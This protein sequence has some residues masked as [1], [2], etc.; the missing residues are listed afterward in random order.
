MVLS[1][2]DGNDAAIPTGGMYRTLGTNSGRNDQTGDVGQ[3]YG[4]VPTVAP[5]NSQNNV[6]GIDRTANNAASSIAQAQ[7]Q[8]LAGL[9]QQMG[10]AQVQYSQG[11]PAGGFQAPM[12]TKDV[13]TVLP[14][15]ADSNENAGAV[16]Q[17][18]RTTTFLLP[19]TGIVRNCF[20][21]LPLADWTDGL[22]AHI[23]TAHQRGVW[24]SFGFTGQIS[25][26][27][28]AVRAY[29][30]G[31]NIEFNPTVMS[32]TQI[33][34]NRVYSSVAISLSDNNKT[35]Q[36]DAVATAGAVM[37]GQSWPKSD[38]S[39]GLVGG[40]QYFFCALSFNDQKP[41][42][43]GAE[44]V[45]RGLHKIGADA[46]SGIAS[47]PPS[48]Q[49]QIVKLQE[50]LPDEKMRIAFSEDG[51]EDARW[52]TVQEFGHVSIAGD[53][54][55]EAKQPV[56]VG[57][58]DGQ[59][60]VA[61]IV[62][63][64]GNWTYDTSV[65][66]TSM[67]LSWDGAEIQNDDYASVGV[68]KDIQRADF[69]YQ[70]MF[71]KES[72]FAVLTQ[73]QKYALYRATGG[74]TYTS[75]SDF[76]AALVR[77]ATDAASIDSQG[78][79]GH[80]LG[81]V[82]VVESP[83]VPME[84][85]YSEMFGYGDGDDSNA[86]SAPRVGSYFVSNGDLRTGSAASK[87]YRIGEKG[88]GGLE[89]VTPAMVNGILFEEAVTIEETG[90]NMTTTE[91]TASGIVT[92]GVHQRVQFID[93]YNDEDTR[94]RVAVSE[95]A[96][97][98]N[99]KAGDGGAQYAFDRLSYGDGKGP[100]G[101]EKK[102]H[103]GRSDNTTHPKGELDM[104]SGQICLNLEQH[105][106]TGEIRVKGSQLSGM[107][108]LDLIQM[109]S[110]LYNYSMR[111]GGNNLTAGPS[112]WYWTGGTQ[113]SAVNDDTATSTSNAVLANAMQADAMAKFAGDDARIPATVDAQ[114]R[115]A[116]LLTSGTYFFQS[117][118]DKLLGKSPD[119]VPGTAANGSRGGAWHENAGMAWNGGSLL[120]PA[121]LVGSGYVGVYDQLVN[122]EAAFSANADAQSH[123]GQVMPTA[124]EVASGE[125]SLR[126]AT[127]TRP[128][129]I[130]SLTTDKPSGKTF[131]LTL[132]D[133]AVQR[134]SGAV[135]TERA[136]GMDDGATNEGIRALVLA[137]SADA[138]AASP[139]SA[140]AISAI[141]G[142]GHKKMPFVFYGAPFKGMQN[143][144]K[145]RKPNS[146]VS[147][148]HWYTGA[149]AQNL[150]YSKMDAAGK[151]AVFDS[152][153]AD[154]TQVRGGVTAEQDPQQASTYA[155]DIG[156]LTPWDTSSCQ[157][158]VVDMVAE[159]K[160]GALD[161]E[162]RIASALTEIGQAAAQS[163]SREVSGRT[164][165]SADYLSGYKPKVI[166]ASTH[167]AR[168]FKTVGGQP[169]KWP[170]ILSGT[171]AS[172]AGPS[173]ESGLKY[174]PNVNSIRNQSQDT[175]SN[176]Q[177]I[178]GGTKQVSWLSSGAA[179][180]CVRGL[181]Q[182]PEE[183]AIGGIVT[184][185][186]DELPISGVPSQ[187]WFGQGAAGG[188]GSASSW[189]LSAAALGENTVSFENADRTVFNS[190][191]LVRQVITPGTNVFATAPVSEAADGQMEF[192]FSSSSTAAKFTTT[193]TRVA[194]GSLLYQCARWP[195]TSPPTSPTRL[196]RPRRPASSRTRAR[197][198]RP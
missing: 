51:A 16:F 143:N 65:M 155:M 75:Q 5:G 6:V 173:D 38:P 68:I 33:E 58:F 132:P 157:W 116:K 171:D 67:G 100:D 93:V 98:E 62:E 130:P 144:Y 193:N 72:P 37:T 82:G 119:Y 131:E 168:L 47:I 149:S 34:S 10:A 180:S 175:V 35:Y 86:T 170:T 11:A 124:S 71:A 94:N 169:S 154:L 77:G 115:D 23:P 44:D 48:V 146:S 14:Q 110:Q 136:A 182:K 139:F 63:H 103:A 159:D 164:L 64:D 74:T 177:L 22:V 108:A 118:K 59:L 163:A 52:H 117:A 187:I 123:S 99:S 88:P 57:G 49:V 24:E 151:K 9:R 84:P 95:A 69:T 150:A 19:H 174:Q 121:K 186:S 179:S 56:L 4:T 183:K 129:Q 158:G 90:A 61:P 148:N 192:P 45:E 141:S 80:L 26:L 36:L 128:Q 105:K 85:R 54:N 165:P 29:G 138:T 194:P 184:K 87:F 114:L 2:E 89:V 135:Y 43:V 79:Q 191:G 66:R 122:R 181:G 153:K 140:P 145:G 25:N 42:A 7:D 137:G 134:T 176:Y 104:S 147:V 50:K 21:M 156:G 127:R 81:A 31:H 166:L 161:D 133:G 102:A 125:V 41:G 142:Y 73:N 91:V 189:D 15:G 53:A 178:Y 55:V 8:T 70:S 197:R 160:S 162:A 60:V 111:V 92:T 13:I 32:G 190:S 46:D 167:Q 198:S 185:S 172:Y 112:S 18:G 113:L 27:T 17:E 20:L 97:V 120:Q 106:E 28:K 83:F 1:L 96:G 3:S 76:G 107:T 12:I 30:F 152:D 40:R 188:I 101:K 195:R 78:V 196:P 39:T 126:K 109:N